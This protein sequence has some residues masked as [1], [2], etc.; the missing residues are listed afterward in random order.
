MRLL[1]M[2]ETACRYFPNMRLVVLSTR[3]SIARRCLSL[4]LVFCLLTAQAVASSCRPDVPTLSPHKRG[5]GLPP[6]DI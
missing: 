5:D 6:Q 3:I 2:H 4:F 1:V